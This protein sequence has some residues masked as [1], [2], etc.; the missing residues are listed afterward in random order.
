MCVY[1]PVLEHVCV[2]SYKF[3][4]PHSTLRRIDFERVCEVEKKNI[5]TA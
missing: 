5:R 1:A 3:R 2:V 4:G